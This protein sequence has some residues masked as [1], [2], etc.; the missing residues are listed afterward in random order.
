MRKRIAIRMKRDK[1]L[2]IGLIPDWF[3]IVYMGGG[4]GVRGDARNR[5]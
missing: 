5:W 3:D 4:S 1:S 2:Y